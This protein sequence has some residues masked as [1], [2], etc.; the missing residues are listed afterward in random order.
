MNIH[1]VPGSLEQTTHS[2]ATRS[3][4]KKADKII[5]TQYSLCNCDANKWKLQLAEKPIG[6]D[7]PTQLQDS[8]ICPPPLTHVCL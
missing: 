8:A 4:S 2:E 6:R 5:S 7:S 1:C 3:S